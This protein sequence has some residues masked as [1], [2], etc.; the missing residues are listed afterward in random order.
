MK[1]TVSVSLGSLEGVS[2]WAPAMKCKAE[3]LSACFIA[4]I[5]K[6][7][8]QSAGQNTVIPQHCS[9]EEQENLL[10]QAVCSWDVALTA[11]I[12]PLG[13]HITAGRT[14][15]CGKSQ[16]LDVYSAAVCLF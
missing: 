8:M 11:H 4:A 1:T 14:S 7:K 2:V 15:T 5:Y 12:F 3:W 6:H 16:V 9:I 10:S 13:M